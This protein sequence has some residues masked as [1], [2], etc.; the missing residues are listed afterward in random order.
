[1]KVSIIVPIYKVEKYLDKCIK[2]ITDQTYKNLEI[3]LVDDGSPDKCPQICDEWATK[4][5]RI[6]VIHKKNGGASSARNAGVE[7]ADGQKIMFVD[8][9]D[10]INSKL[11]EFL[12]NAMKETGASL[13]MSNWRKIYSIDEENI[14][15]SEYK[16]KTFKN[17]EVFELLFNKKVPLIMVPWA[18]LFDIHLF[19]NIRYSEDYSLAEDEHI[20][21]KILIKTKKLA[22]VDLPLYNNLQRGDSLTGVKFNS[23]KLQVLSALKDRWDFCKTNIPKY[24]QMALN[25]YLVSIA[26]NYCRFKMAG[27]DK[28]YLQKIL[29]LFNENYKNLKKKSLAILVF[30]YFRPLFFVAVKLKDRK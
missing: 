26:S 12:F 2:S 20:I 7:L 9:D 3:I 6:K 16:Y 13:A 1:M 11:V 18:K 23:D 30:K 22:Y 5:K 21:H 14:N 29:N 27:G 24:E 17:E 4:D 25:Q 15:F 10:T 8:G 19:E 28:V